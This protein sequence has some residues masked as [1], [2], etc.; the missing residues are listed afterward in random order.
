[1]MI[2]NWAFLKSMIG[3][4]VGIIPPVSV[5]V[6]AIIIHGI[7]RAMSIELAWLFLIFSGLLG[8]GIGYLYE[9]LK[10]SNFFFRLFLILFSL[11]FIILTTLMALFAI[12]GEMLH[13]IHGI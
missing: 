11:F 4:I 1:M 8:L 9:C 2:K 3:L 12:I 5:F 10:N 7:D 6:A 13:P